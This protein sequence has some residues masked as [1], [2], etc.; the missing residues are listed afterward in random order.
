M[1]AEIAALRRE[2][3][4]EPLRADT[5]IRGAGLALDS[6]E[7]LEVALAVTRM[8]HIHETGLEDMLLRPTTA[9]GWAEVVER[10]LKEYSGKITFRSSG[11]IA[12]PKAW[13]HERL[14]LDQEA[15]YWARQLPVRQRVASLVPAHHIYGFIWAALL[16][17]HLRLPVISL[18]RSAVSTVFGQLRDGDLVLS[19]P[20]GW[21][22]MAQCGLQFPQGVIGV[23]SGGP[24][25]PLV[26]KTLVATCGLGQML[27]IYGA[28]ETGGIGFRTDSGSAF[29]LADYWS[30]PDDGSEGRLLRLRP[31]GSTPAHELPDVLEWCDDRRFCVKGRRDQAVQVAGINVYPQRIA[32]LLRRDAA[33]EDC[34]VRLMQPHEGD[35]LKAF[36]VL[37]PGVP[38]RLDVRR[39]IEQRLSLQVSGLEMPRSWTYGRALPVSEMGK[40]VDWSIDNPLDQA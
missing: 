30:K 19:H 8:F 9:G 26:W 2:P 5:V 23:V 34:A 40:S 17:T 16:P 20:L 1:E 10:S 31:D 25:S 15:A 18:H 21:K 29:Q 3:L 32:N 11:T 27:E 24:A 6:L 39:S 28:S 14:L 36:V 38:D 33:V 35:R 4:T 22:M 12:E 7:L 13:T 37:A